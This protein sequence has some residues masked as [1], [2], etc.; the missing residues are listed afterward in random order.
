M[1]LPVS[2]AVFLALSSGVGASA[3]PPDEGH[4]P[5]ARGACPVRDAPGQGAL[6]AR[7]S[8]AAREASARGIERFRGGNVARSTSTGVVLA[9]LIFL[10]VILI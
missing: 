4:G 9:V 6:L 8:Y 10:T 7:E 3:Q 1:R 2:L 5:I